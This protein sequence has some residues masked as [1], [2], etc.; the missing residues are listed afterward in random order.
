LSGSCAS[1][2][3]RVARA[4][5]S[6]AACLRDAVGQPIATLGITRDVSLRHEA[7]AARLESEQ[8]FEVLARSAFEVIT[9]LD[10]RGRVIWANKSAPSA[11]FHRAPDAPARARPDLIH[12]DDREQ[13]VAKFSAAFR[14]GADTSI[15]FRAA[16]VDG[17]WHSL[18]TFVSPFQTREG[19]RRMLLMSR[20]VTQRRQILDELRVSEERFRL[21][22]DHANDSIE[23]F[24]ARGR[25]LYANPRAI[26]ALG[27]SPE[28]FFRVPP[29]ERI[30]PDDVAAF[31]SSFGA[32]VREPKSIFTS[33]RARHQDGSWHWF[34]ANVHSHRNAQGSCVS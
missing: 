31:R 24:D 34:E 25:L 30:H 28:D 1:S 29:I 3:R 13:T 8:R 7:E 32:V 15:S 5:C 10:Q 26:E 4:G 23:E 2:P 21:L 9:E 12:P 19:E 14:D 6:I 16:D 33:V 27:T 22:A 20:D 18:E 17:S 11:R